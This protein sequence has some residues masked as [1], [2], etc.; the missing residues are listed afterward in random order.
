MALDGKAPIV[1]RQRE[2]AQVRAFLSPPGRARTLVIGGEP[3]IGKTTVWEA[4][5]DLARELGWARA[6]GK[7]ERRAEA[8]LPFAAL[9]DLCDGGA[10]RWR[11][12]RLRSDCALEV[13]LLRAEPR[14]GGARAVRDRARRVD[15]L[16]ALARRRAAALIAVDD[17]PWLDAASAEALAFVARRLDGEPIAF[18]LARRPGRA[19]GLERALAPALDGWRSGG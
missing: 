9:I 4:A 14:R 17:V 11:G 3:G 2:L 10:R 1:G 8:R 7:A 15:A 13:A 19:T 12:R 5:I 18:L 16:R 6:V